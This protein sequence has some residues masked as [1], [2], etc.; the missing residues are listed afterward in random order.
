MAVVDATSLDFRLL[1]RLAEGGSAIHRLDPRAKVLVTVIFIV[2]VVSFGKYELSALVPFFV[3]P[4]AVIARAGLPPYLIARKVA[5]VLPFALLIGI[6]NPLLDREILFHLGP[7]AVSG[8]WVSCAS[9]LARAVLT[10]SAAI[11]LLAVTGFPA[12]CAAMERL[13]M[14]RAFGVQL[15]FLYRYIFVLMEEAKRAALAREL[16]TF[17]RRGLE[18]KTFASLVGHLLLRTWERADRIHRAMLARGF[19]GRF[20]VRRAFR[21]GAG[22]TLFLLGWSAIFILFRL[23]NIPRLVG[24]F[25]TGVFG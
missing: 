23:E 7:L 25:V 6:F 20:H 10:V 22:E 8:G 15:M 16:R 17:G 21:F 5:L 14:P 1:D 12:I 11:T 24:S 3:F 13:G 4:A 19:D 2:M 9:I 18:M